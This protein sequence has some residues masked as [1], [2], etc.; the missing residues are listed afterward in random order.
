M[1]DV[2]Y[3][4]GPVPGVSRD[5]RRLAAVMK[6]VSVVCIVDYPRST[7]GEALRDVAHTLYGP[8]G[9]WEIASR[10]HGYVTAFSEEEF[11]ERCGEANV[12]WIIPKEE[13]GMQKA[14]IGNGN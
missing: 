7:G 4:L 9:F 13:G 3:R 1:S 12:E 2:I 14:E 5:Y 11:I 6:S 8:N 10:G